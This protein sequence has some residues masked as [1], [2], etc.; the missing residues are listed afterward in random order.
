MKEC[1]K[2]QVRKKVHSVP[3]EVY[4]RAFQRS[5]AKMNECF[6]DGVRMFGT[7]MCTEYINK[8]MEE[9]FKEKV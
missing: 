4:E 6:K 1:F 9:R 8:E 5:G 2:E 3:I 7:L